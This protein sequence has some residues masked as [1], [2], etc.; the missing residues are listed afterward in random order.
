MAFKDGSTDFFQNGG[1]VTRIAQLGRCPIYDITAFM[2]IG[3]LTSWFPTWSQDLSW[4]FQGLAQ[5]K[6]CFST[7]GY[8]ASRRELCSLSFT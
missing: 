8:G 2:E 3:G 6:S 5:I 4:F 7:F 1:V